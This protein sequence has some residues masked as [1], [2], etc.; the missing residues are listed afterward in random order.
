MIVKIDG[1]EYLHKLRDN[2]LGFK[3]EIWQQLA[4]CE[5]STEVECFLKDNEKTSSL[6]L[7]TSNSLPLRFNIPTPAYDGSFL[8]VY[9][10]PF[11]SL[12]CANASARILF[13][14][15]SNNNI[16][17]GSLPE[18]TVFNISL[19]STLFVEGITNETNFGIS[20]IS[21][22][23]E[24]SFTS[25]NVEDK[26]VISCTDNHNLISVGI[27]KLKELPGLKYEEP[28]ATN[29]QMGYNSCQV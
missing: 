3:E 27:I 17:L 9:V 16:W 8:N 22:V 26:I 20:E 23:F 14:L 1:V 4:V 18:S 29:A 10:I 25:F 5:K 7:N 19:K 21:E 13:Q 11:Y 28:Y 12:F 6:I 2:V 15:P 24:F